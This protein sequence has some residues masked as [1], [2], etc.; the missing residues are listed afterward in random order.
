MCNGARD[1]V[2]RRLLDWAL[3]PGEGVDQHGRP[4]AW[5]LDCRELTLHGPTLAAI[6]QLLWPLVSAHEPELVAGPTL[7]A[8]PLVS[9]LLLVAERQGMQLAAVS[10]G[11]RRNATGSGS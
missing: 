7:S 6:A 4:L 1:L 2:R 8:D 3:K 5:S 11:R 10:Y 9:A